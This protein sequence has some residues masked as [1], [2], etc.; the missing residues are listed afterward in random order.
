M[1]ILE[2][3][4]EEDLQINIIIKRVNI[5][6]NIDIKKNNHIIYMYIPNHFPEIDYPILP[7]SVIHV[8]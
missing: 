7:T 6:S 8:R 1:T 5:S 4:R 2:I 3:D